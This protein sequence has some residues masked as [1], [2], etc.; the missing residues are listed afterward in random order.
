VG[1]IRVEQLDRR[2]CAIIEGKTQGRA[3]DRR[4]EA[5]KGR[6]PAIMERGSE[7]GGWDARE[8]RQGSGTGDLNVTC[9]VGW[10]GMLNR[11]QTT[12]GRSREYAPTEG[13]RVEDGEKKNEDL[14]SATW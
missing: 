12:G 3:S 10:G 9:I 8:E 13:L 7:R 1:R 5:A 6:G 4:K 2:Q 11:S 14:R